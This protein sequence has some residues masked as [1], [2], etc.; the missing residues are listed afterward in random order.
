LYFETHSG[1]AVKNKSYS[2]GNIRQILYSKV[3]VGDSKRYMSRANIK[4]PPE[5]GSF[6]EG[7]IHQFYDSVN[8]PIS[9][10]DSSIRVGDCYVV[11]DNVCAYPAYVVDFAPVA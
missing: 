4:R 5:K 8:A 2:K 11:Y 10:L 6:R 3:V 7:E 9:V 1:Y